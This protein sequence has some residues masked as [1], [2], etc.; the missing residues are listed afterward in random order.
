MLEHYFLKPGTVDRLRDSWIGDPIERYVQWLSE[1]GYA[2]RNVY[3]RVPTLRK[4]GEFAQQQGATNFADL[5]A[6]VEPF[7]S[8]WV[9]D[10]GSHYK[11]V[12]RWIEHDGR[13]P[14]EQMLVLILPGYTGKGRSQRVK[15]PFSKQAPDFL[16]FLREERGLRE[17]SIIHYCHY[18]RLFET[19]LKQIHLKHF[20]DL[21]PTILSAFIIKEGH[22]LSKS[23][24]TGLCSS[25]R[26]FLRYLRREGL[27]KQDINQLHGHKIFN[28]YYARVIQLYVDPD[29]YNINK[30]RVQFNFQ[31]VNDSYRIIRN[32]TEGLYVYNYND[33]SR[34]L[35][36]AIEYKEF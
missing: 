3:R 17:R 34:Q 35:L 36:H 18:L 4:F 16:L 9:R 23:S 14:V 30:A 12:P 31:T 10:H 24:T 25:L 28:E 29:K 15:D 20:I 13:T 7:V 11:E 6:F 27:I 33:E 26:V 21:T 8:Q 5:P 2:A 19:Y 1:N 22:R 32:A